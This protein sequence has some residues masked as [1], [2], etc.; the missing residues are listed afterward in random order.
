MT[1]RFPS[2]WMIS[3]LSEAGLR[4]RLSEARTM[5][6]YGHTQ[7]LR[8]EAMA[9]IERIRAELARRGAAN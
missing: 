4:E 6:M 5:L 2:Q 7:A 8:E 9:T 1:S 3:R